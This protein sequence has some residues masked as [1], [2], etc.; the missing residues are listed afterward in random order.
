MFFLKNNIL[1]NFTYALSLLSL[2]GYQY[3]F[4]FFF[5][6][7]YTTVSKWSLGLF[8]PAGHIPRERYL[9]LLAGHQGCMTYVRKGGGGSLGNVFFQCVVLSH[10]YA[11]PSLWLTLP[12]WGKTSIL[13]S[14]Q[15]E[16]GAGGG[17]GP[18][19]FSYW[20]STH[21]AVSSHNF[22]SKVLTTVPEATNCWARGGFWNAKQVVFSFLGPLD[23]VTTQWS[24]FQLLKWSCS[25]PFQILY[26]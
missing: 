10:N 17:G 25:Y 26:P 18:Q 19:C 2:W 3:I 7:R 23:S 21:A 22:T 24:A 14:Q 5:S 20:L 15:Q 8:P 4:V 16:E 12:P 11:W 6:Q 1:K 13:W 9:N